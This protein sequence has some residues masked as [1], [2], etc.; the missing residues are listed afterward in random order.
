[1]DRQD[2]IDAL[3][4]RFSDRL[5]YD[6]TTRRQAEWAVELLEELGVLPNWQPID[7]APKDSHS[8]LVWCPERLNIY[9]VTWS[10]NGEWVHFGSG[11]RPL[12]QE[13][14]HWAPLPVAP[15]PA[16]ADLLEQIKDRAP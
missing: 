12:T 7:S 11:G 9:I 15:T 2:L 10:H 6:T 16:I 1:M 5:D 8:R 4:D 14:T 3:S 13:A